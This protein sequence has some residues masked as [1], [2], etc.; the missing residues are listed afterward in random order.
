MED[1]VEGKVTTLTGVGLSP[2]KVAIKLFKKKAQL[3]VFTCVRGS[4]AICPE[5]N[6]SPNSR[7]LSMEAS[8]K[9]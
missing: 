3:K 2:L 4:P 8:E 9:Q 7:N 6:C 1:L 5:Q